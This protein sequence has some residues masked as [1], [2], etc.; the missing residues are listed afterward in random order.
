TSKFLS[1]VFERRVLATMH[2]PSAT[3]D[4]LAMSRK[5]LG[6]PLMNRSYRSFTPRDSTKALNR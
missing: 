1:L 3:G 6:Q 5:R 2:L 4:P